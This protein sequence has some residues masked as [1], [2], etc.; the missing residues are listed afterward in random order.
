[1]NILATKEKLKQFG[2][3][4]RLKGDTA[5]KIRILQQH[6]DRIGIAPVTDEE[7]KEDK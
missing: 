6:C 2:V 3:N 1:M 4:T 5:D 7:V